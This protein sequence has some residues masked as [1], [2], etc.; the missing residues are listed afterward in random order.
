MASSDN[1]YVIIKSILAA[2]MVVVGL[3]STVI[4]LGNS[5]IKFGIIVLIVVMGVVW[6]VSHGLLRRTVKYVLFAVMIFSISFT[7]F[8][9]YLLWN[10]GYPPTYSSQSDVTISYP[11]ILNASL[12]DVVQSV[13]TSLTFKLLR[14]EYLGE[15]NIETITLDTGFRS[16]R[17]E[18]VLYQGSSKI[19]F[20]F[21]ATGGESYRA[22]IP[23]WYGTPLSQR[24]PQK[25]TLYE[26]LQ[27]ID[28]LGL[29]WYYDCA[30]GAYQ[31]K[32]GVAPEINNL[33]ISV[34]YE[35]YEAYMGITLLMI[36]S[37]VD[38][39]GR[40]GGVFFANFQPD[41][42]LNYINTR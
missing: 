34:Q 14:L 39:G 22:T 9:G 33:Q 24:Y 4:F 10:A 26:T 19:G 15:V 23:R 32:T 12:I 31:N 20:R 28:K 30:I 40:G 29:Q 37:Y 7:A 5:W 16:G 41:G 8:E 38:S 27:Q 1:K 2:V 42:T 36:G 11:N 17:V 3:C 6:L 18:V 21:S 25:Q 35:C 13:E